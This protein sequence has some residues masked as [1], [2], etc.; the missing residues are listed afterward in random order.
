MKALESIRQ[1]LASHVRQR[2]DFVG[3]VAKREDL[4]GACRVLI[5]SVQS[6]NDPKIL[7]NHL[8]IQVKRKDYVQIN[9]DDWIKFSGVVTKYQRAKQL[10]KDGFV[11]S[12]DYGVK[13][14]KNVEIKNG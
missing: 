5:V 8:W 10:T 4:F 3:L 7:L 9:N 11:D 1:S 14:V 2:L 13:L 6:H 12:W